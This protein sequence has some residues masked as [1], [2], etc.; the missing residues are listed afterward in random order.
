MHAKEHLRF[1]QLLLNGVEEVKPNGHIHWNI[2]IKA[3]RIPI[4]MKLNHELS[5]C[6]G[7]GYNIMY[8]TSFLKKNCGC[9]VLWFAKPTFGM[10][11]VT[12][13]QI[14]YWRAARTRKSRRKR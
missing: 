2:D 4:I 5:K 11:K 6:L 14:A 10:S 1:E 9:N 12:L 3:A 7:C 8:V 13:L